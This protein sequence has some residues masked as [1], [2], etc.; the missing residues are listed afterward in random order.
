MPKAF[1]VGR[2]VERGEQ[3]EGRRD[4]PHHWTNVAKI[5]V[6]AQQKR[7]RLTIK[8]FVRIRMNWDAEW[9]SICWPPTNPIP[10]GERIPMRVGKRSDSQG[11]GWWD[12]DGGVGGIRKVSELFLFG[13]GCEMYKSI[14]AFASDGLLN[15]PHNNGNTWAA[16]GRGW[17]GDRWVSIPCP[18]HQTEICMNASAESAA[19]VRAYHC[20]VQ[21]TNC[22]RWRSPPS[23]SNLHM[24][25][26]WK[27]RGERGRRLC[28]CICLSAPQWD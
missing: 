6:N 15:R 16:S 22:R 10:K 17:T 9:T 21:S 19:F 23:G 20:P 5:F 14:C 18:E 12:V 3:G 28:I 11:I 1:A 2:T 4:C 27:R 7:F 13:A 26:S 8:T 25:E 24:E